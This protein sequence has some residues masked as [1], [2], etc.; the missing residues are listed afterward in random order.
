MMTQSLRKEDTDRKWV[1]IDARDAV[2]GRLS[3]QVATL[4]RGKHKPS[5]TPHVDNGDNVIIINAGEVK[6]TGRKAEQKTYFRYTGWPGGDRFRSYEDLRTL[7]PEAIVQHAV[8]GMLPKSRLGRKMIKKL[9]VYPGPE[10][11][12]QAQRPESFQ[13]AHK[14]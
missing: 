8:R 7:R 1:V 3:S 2:L 4:L 10:H 11:P 5:F 6:V 12:H 9:H 13:L 14:A